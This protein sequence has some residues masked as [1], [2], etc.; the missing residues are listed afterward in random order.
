MV[1]RAFIA[2]RGKGL[3]RA[4]PITEGKWAVDTL[5]LDQ[6]VCYL[7]ADPCNP[8]RL[9]VGTRGSGVLRSEDGGKTWQS[10]GLEGRIVKSIAICRADSQVI[11]AGTKPPG[12]FV[13][14]NGGQTWTEQE[15]FRRLRRWFWFTP[16]E[17]GDPY[18]MGL[19]VS[20]TDPNLVIAGV[21]LGGTFR[22]V[23]GGQTWQGHLK[24]T[25]RD[26]H[27]LRF[28]QTNGNWVYQAGGGWPAAVSADGG[29]TWKQPRRGLG[30]SLYG[31]AVAAD[32]ADPSIWYASAA[33][34]AVFPQLNKMPRGHFAGEANA[35]LFRRRGNSRWERLGG[36][37]PQPLDYM[38]YTL[39]T[40]SEAP[41]HLYAGLSN[42]DVW[43]TADYGD[44]W[45]QLP[46][47]LGNIWTAMIIL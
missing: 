10:A 4:T 34:H 28:H 24:S 42:G 41:G 26:C 27:S 33:P 35:F 18:V 15:S 9:Y 7:T 40:D 6:E 1:D 38:A 3:A 36:G 45:Q 37:L 25:S 20:P 14:R 32:P 16:A 31:M 43:H 29:L 23:D 5:L 11:Y 19:A 46:F 13:T 39:V 21:E 47:N 8:N 17:P 2:T 22:S 30:W 12:I 44:H